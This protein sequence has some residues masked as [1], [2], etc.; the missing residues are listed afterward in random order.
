MCKGKVGLSVGAYTRSSTCVR[1]KEGLSVGGG[2]G[3]GL[4]GREIRYASLVTKS[5]NLFILNQRNCVI[6]SSASV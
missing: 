3:G 6:K 1:E 2:G 4:I 5:R